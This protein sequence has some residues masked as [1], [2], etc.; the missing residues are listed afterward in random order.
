M[1]AQHAALQLGDQ[2][3]TGVLKHQPM[4]ALLALNKE[5]SSLIAEQLCAARGSRNLILLQGAGMQPLLL[6]GVCELV[7]CCCSVR[8]KDAMG[9]RAM[10]MAGQQEEDVAHTVLLSVPTLVGS[11]WLSA[12]FQ[13]CEAS[14]S[15]CFCACALRWMCVEQNHAWRGCQGQ[16]ASI[17]ISLQEN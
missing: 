1:P 2:F 17:C 3:D 9:C 12:G 14:R 4:P 10:L 6:C 7:C 5:S 8:I 11:A 13:T 16:P 15:I